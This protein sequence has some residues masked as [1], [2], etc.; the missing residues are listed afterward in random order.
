MKDRK[1]FTRLEAIVAL[2]DLCNQIKNNTTELAQRC[3]RGVKELEYL[4]QLYE[5]AAA[6]QEWSKLNGSVS[7]TV[8]FTPALPGFGESDDSYAYFG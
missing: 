8:Q 4:N 5:T 6:L 1:Q 2:N 7:I 3:P